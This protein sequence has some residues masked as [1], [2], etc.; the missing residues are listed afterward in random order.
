MN[1]APLAAYLILGLLFGA[2]AAF[3]GDV[4]KSSS[5]IAL[6]A[7]ARMASSR[8]TKA[9]LASIA[10]EIEASSGE[11]KPTLCNSFLPMSVIDLA[12][13]KSVGALSAVPFR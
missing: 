2:F 13:L 10:S 9:S 7:A 4:A 8:A 11:A 5:S 3:A 6:S 1:I 12:W